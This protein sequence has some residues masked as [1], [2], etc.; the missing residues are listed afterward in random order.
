MPI[1]PNDISWLRCWLKLERLTKKLLVSLY[2]QSYIPGIFF[3]KCD[4][5]SCGSC[6]FFKVL[7]ELIDDGLLF[8]DTI[9]PL[10]SNVAAAFSQCRD[11]LIV[12]KGEDQISYVHILVSSD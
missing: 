5:G 4:E 10:E 3:F 6:Q 9:E 7:E 2:F 12:V 11:Q 1:L 8:L